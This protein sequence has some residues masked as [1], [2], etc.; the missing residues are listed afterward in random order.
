MGPMGP[1]SKYVT[2]KRAQGWLVLLSARTF[3]DKAANWHLVVPGALTAALAFRAGGFFPDTVG[4]AAGLLCLLLVARVTLAERPFS[5][6]SAP[7]ALTTGVPALFCAWTL[8]SSGWSSA[9]ARAVVELDRALLYLLVLAFI[10]LHPRAPGNLR[11]LL[12]WLGLA[13]AATCAVALATRL[14]PSTFPTA[15]GVNNER[16]AFPVTYWNAMGMFCGLGAIVLT[17]LT[18]SEREPAAVRVAAAAGLPVV[19]V[20]LYFTFSRGG[21]AAGCAG[22]V[23]YMLLAHPRGLL[24]ALPAAGLPVAFALQRAYDS[25]LLARYDYSGA[26]AREQGKT[27]L[28]V[29]IGSAVAAALLRTLALRVDRRMLRIR[30]GSRT[31]RRVFAAAGV[32]ALVAFAV[33]SLAF[34]LP[35]RVD[36]QREAFVRGNAPPGGRDLRT[37][38]TAVGNNGRLAIWRVALH[39]A[40]ERPWRGAGAGTYRLQWERGRPAPPAQVSDAH[41]LY[42]ELRAELGWIGVVLIAIVLAV[43][44][45]VAAVR[46]RGPGR[47]AY[48]AFI[49]AGIALLAHAVVDWDWEMPTLF[50]WFF[51]AAGVILAAPADG[52][53]SL[54]PPRRLTR[55]VASLACLLVAVTPMTVAFSQLR[56]NRSV[57]AFDRRDCRTA[58][59]AALSSLDALPAQAQAF[60]ILGWCDARAGRAGL[61]IDAMRAAQRRDPDNW[62]YAYGLAVSQ[63]LAGQDPRPAAQRALR[64]NPLEP[65]TRRLARDMQAGT[66]KRRRALAARSAIPSG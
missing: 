47:H 33:A 59:D 17:H 37:R 54:P 24:G 31:R 4:L 20:T 41:S 56:L 27:L 6:W 60:E 3:V 65:L 30:I 32:T 14:L 43:P 23:L 22:V 52:A 34:D 11:L 57:Q 12:R 7:L 19:A 36:E 45:V 16:L 39:T 13:L 55:V 8:A 35:E 42:F 5:G 10:G 40:D 21:I 9:P 62:Q 44:L 15:T 26:D 2:T 29:V 64:L 61:A 48:A 50:V 38:L 53:G 58:T 1:S 63:A 18:A 25:E 66:A 49:A 51:G 46:L 28:V